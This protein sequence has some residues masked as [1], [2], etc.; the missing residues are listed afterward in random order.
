MFVKQKSSHRRRFKLT[1]LTFSFLVWE[2]CGDTGLVNETNKTVEKEVILED[3]L[4]FFLKGCVAKSSVTI[5]A[6]NSK[7][8][9]GYFKASSMT[10]FFSKNTY[11]FR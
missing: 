1:T 2:R 8:E 10:G 11:L 5:N 9:S 4:E 6:R 7:F 3:G